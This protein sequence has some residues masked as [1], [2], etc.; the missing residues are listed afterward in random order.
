MSGLFFTF[1]T[2]KQVIQVNTLNIINVQAYD[3]PS[4]IKQVSVQ[5]CFVTI[6]TRPAATVNYRREG[7]GTEIKTFFFD[8]SFERDDFIKKLGDH[9]IAQ[10]AI[11][12]APVC[13]E[14]EFKRF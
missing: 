11:C 9:M 1:T 4:C 12:A 14:N 6:D 3:L 7:C 10:N 2:Q 5:F 8:S 13:V